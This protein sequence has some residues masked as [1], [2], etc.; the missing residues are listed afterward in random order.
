MKAITPIS[1]ANHVHTSFI[2]SS[3]NTHYSSFNTFS[4]FLLLYRFRFVSSFDT[5]LRLDLDCFVANTQHAPDQT[6]AI[7]G[8]EGKMDFGDDQFCVVVAKARRRGFMDLSADFQIR[9]LSFSFAF[10]R[11]E[12][13]L[14]L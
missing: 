10:S 6:V 14:G 13:V 5:V 2:A 1:D 7:D 4:F 12:R 9:V 11:V 3:T 8:N